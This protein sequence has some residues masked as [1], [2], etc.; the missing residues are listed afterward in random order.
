MF[1]SMHAEAREQSVHAGTL[2]RSTGRCRRGKLVHV[3]ED[4]KAAQLALHGGAPVRARLLPYGR[5]TIDDDDVA[6][7]VRALRSDW[8]TSG[9]AV[10]PFQAA[11][12]GATG[13]APRQGG[14]GCCSRWAGAR[15]TR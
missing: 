1:A 6:A 3:P 5:H 13:A 10:Q 11:V 7:V 12:A 8:L 15:A 14:T 4:L 2:Y 9:P